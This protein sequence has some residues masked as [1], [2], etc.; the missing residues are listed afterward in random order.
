MKSYIFPGFQA[1]LEQVVLPRATRYPDWER[2]D[3][4]VDVPGR[5]VAKFDHEGATYSINGESRVAALV[6]VLEW[7]RAHPGE[8]P[9]VTQPHERGVTRLTLRPEITAVDS[10]SVRI[11]SK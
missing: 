1:V 2:L 8:N 10:K 11:A 6:A 7:M 5:T 3:G 9:L 4:A